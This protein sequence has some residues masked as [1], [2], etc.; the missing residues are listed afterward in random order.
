MLCGNRFVD[1]PRVWISA[2]GSLFQREMSL[3][4]GRIGHLERM[5]TVMTTRIQGMEQMRAFLEGTGGVEF[6]IP[7]RLERHAWI[8][9]TLDRAGYRRLRRKERGVVVRYLCKVTGCSRQQI[10]R[11][12]A[13]WRERGVV[14]D[15]RKGPAK[16]FATRYSIS[17]SIVH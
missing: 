11:L 6:T 5:L 9:Q 12:I 15:G 10:T 1:Y 7:G 3:K 14:E 17:S 13:Q 8:A 2:S 4:P 16:P